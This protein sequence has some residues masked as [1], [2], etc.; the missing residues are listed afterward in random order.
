MAGRPSK[1]ESHVQP[2]LL[3]IEAWARDGL[4]EADICKNLDVGKDAF[5]SYKKEYPE[6]VEALKN[7]KEVIDVMVENALLK[8]ALGYEYVEDGV[9]KDGV[10][11]LTKYAHPN[12]TALIFWLKN[13]KP[14][15]WRDKQEIGLDGD[16]NIKVALPKGFGVDADD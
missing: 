9:G 14:K 5:I 7:G 15:S 4:T 12:T 1:Y 2:K 10:Y 8:A 11:S 16:L 3:L 13:R 6:L